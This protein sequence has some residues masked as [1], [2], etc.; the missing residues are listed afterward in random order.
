MN[1]FK[2]NAHLTIIQRAFKSVRRDTVAKIQNLYYQK[3]RHIARTEFIV[4]LFL[5]LHPIDIACLSLY[6]VTHW[7]GRLRRQ[8]CGFYESE[9]FTI[10]PFDKTDIG[11]TTKMTVFSR[12]SY[13]H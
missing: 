2:I 3:K 13:M 4:L 12:E 7:H 11:S 1:A 5:P 8:M 9:V 6:L 10:P